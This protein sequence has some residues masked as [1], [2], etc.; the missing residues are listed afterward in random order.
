VQ[1]VCNDERWPNADLSLVHTLATI[2]DLLGASPEDVVWVLG[3]EGTQFLLDSD[4]RWA[5]LPGGP[6]PEMVTTADGHLFTSTNPQAHALRTIV[7]DFRE[8]SNWPNI[9]TN[10]ALLL[11]DISMKLDV[12]PPEIWWALGPEGSRY[13]ADRCGDAISDQVAQVHATPTLVLPAREELS[14]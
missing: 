6:R 13:V 3:S 2:L 11:F 14:A 10:A 12:P 4:E 1:H 9:A 7:D 8:E 5:T